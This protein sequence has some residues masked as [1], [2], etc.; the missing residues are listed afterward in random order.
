MTRRDNADIIGGAIL[1][2]FGAFIIIYAQRYQMGTLLRMGPG[3]YP[4]VLGALL[5]LLGL[6]IA[7]PAFFREGKP[8]SV[9]IRPFVCV[10]GS[11]LFFAYALQPVGL[12]L[13]TAGTILFGSFATSALLWRARLGLILVIPAIT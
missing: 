13:T 8:V 2:A 12:I 5:V 7:L 3:Y 9:Q 6:I 11:L 1:C 4:V 10:V